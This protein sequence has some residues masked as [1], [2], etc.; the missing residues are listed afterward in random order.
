MTQHLRRS[1]VTKALTDA[2][3]AASFPDAEARLDAVDACI[4]LGDD[5]ASTRAGQAAALTAVATAFKCFGRVTLAMR[6]PAP[7]L[8]LDFP[9]GATLAGAAA[10]LGARIVA[11]APLGATHRIAIG[12]GL[13]GQGWEVSCWWDRWLSGLRTEG[14]ACGDSRLGLAGVYAGALAV[15]QIFASVLVGPTYMARDSTLSLW[16]PWTEVPADPGPIRFTAPNAL[17]LVGLGHLG[18]G[19]VWNLLTLPYRCPRH[20]VL[21]DDQRIGVENEPTSLLVVEPGERRRKVRVAAG[22]LDP[23][24]W[25]TRLIERRHRGDIQPTKDDPPVLLCGLDDVRPRRILATLGFDYMIDAGIGHGPGDFEG[26][27]IRTIPKGAPSK[28]LWNAPPPPRALDDLLGK[29]AYRALEAQAQGCGAYTLA[30]GSVAVPFVGAATGALTIAQAIRLASMKPAV[31]LIQIGLAA[32]EM[33]IDG[34]LCPAPETS[35]GGEVMDLDAVAAASA[36]YTSVQVSV[37]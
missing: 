3:I 29:A 7:P 23:A 16:E 36:S 6:A 17:W 26:L 8:L 24:G 20:A 34:G 13:T 25:D 33:Q 31:A 4:V 21:Q 22:W 12:G 5:Q 1:R 11:K 15:R 30:D 10:R 18:Q 19:F 37:E 35:F 2:G 28:D 14:A 27:Q 32:P 9:L